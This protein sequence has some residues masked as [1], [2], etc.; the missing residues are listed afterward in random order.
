MYDSREGIVPSTHDPSELGS[1]LSGNDALTL[2]E[3]VQ[4]CLFSK[5]RK[6][7]VSIFPKLQGL[8]AFDYADAILGYHDDKTGIVSDF[9]IN[10]SM[11]KEWIREYISRKYLQ[12]DP[13]VKENFMFYTPQYW[14]DTKKKS[15]CCKEMNSLYNDFG[16]KEGYTHGSR[17]QVTGK[18]GSKICFSS[19]SMKY[20]KRT[21]AILEIVV[22]H[23]HLALYHLYDRRHPENAGV[24][25][26]TREREVLNWLKQGKTSWDISV[27]LGISECTVNYHVY[28]IM[29]K[30]GATNRPQAVAVATRLGL[31]DFD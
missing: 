26:T 4:Q 24:T 15:A 3:I 20:D 9:G 5:S 14:S 1:C 6:D 30:L 29:E 16:M 17:L 25:L 8:F 7:F 12:I 28:N 31:I 10:V 22:P 27:I 18:Y 13:I 11:P 19:P 23:L 2:L 21:F